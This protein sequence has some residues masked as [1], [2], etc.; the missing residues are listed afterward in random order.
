M[1]VSG[2]AITLMS[3]PKTRR[4]ALSALESSQYIDVGELVGNRLAIV[5]DTPDSG[6]DRDLWQWLNDLP[7]VAFV[8]VVSVHMADDDQDAGTAGGPGNGSGTSTDAAADRD[9][10]AS[11]SSQGTQP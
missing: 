1:P 2:L 4:D 10:D 11:S 5:I 3:D 8:D 7:G 9:Y 6:T